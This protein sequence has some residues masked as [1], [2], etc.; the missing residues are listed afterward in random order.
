MGHHTSEQIYDKLETV[1]QSYYSYLWMDRILTALYDVIQESVE[2]E[3]GR[4]LFNLGS[5]GLDIYLMMISEIDVML[6][7]GTLKIVCPV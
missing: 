6:L 7:N 3:T 2:K 1:F 5:C 4:T